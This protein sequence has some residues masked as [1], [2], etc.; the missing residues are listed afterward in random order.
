MMMNYKRGYYAINQNGK[1]FR[2]TA[3]MQQLGIW[4]D[5]FKNEKSLQLQNAHLSFEFWVQ[6]TCWHT[7]KKSI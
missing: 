6:Q 3:S 2:A 5:D 7:K 4:G 1:T